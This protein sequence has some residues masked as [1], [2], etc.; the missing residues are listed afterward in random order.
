MQVEA[1]VPLRICLSQFNRWLQTLRLEK[2]LIF[3]TRQHSASAPPPSRKLCTFLTWSDWDLGVC[4]HYECKRKQIHKPDAVNSWIDLRSTYRMFYSRKPKGLNGALQD[5]GIQFCGREHSGLDDA[6]NTARL[7][8]RMMR[9]GCVMKITRSLEREEKPKNKPTTST[10]SSVANAT[11]V[12][13]LQDNSGPR[14]SVPGHESLVSPK[15]LLNGTTSPLC[16]LWSKTRCATAANLSNNL[17]LCSTVM[18]GLQ[19]QQAVRSGPTGL[20]EERVEEFAVEAEDRCGSYDDVV[21]DDVGMDSGGT[22]EAVSDH[23]SLW[24]EPKETPA[25]TAVCQG[26]VPGGPDACFAVLQTASRHQLRHKTNKTP[27]FVPERT[28]TPNASIFRTKGGIAPSKSPFTVLADSWKKVAASASRRVPKTVLSSIPA[29]VIP[30]RGGK[31]TPPLCDCGRRTKR[32]QVS[33]SGP[34]HGRGFY[35]CA[36]R[37]ATRKGCEFFKWESTLKKTSSVS[38]CHADRMLG[39]RRSQRKS[40]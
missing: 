6:K 33:N 38:L 20:E 24:G 40:V 37:Q 21:L 14:V 5:L 16:G 36:V 35:C 15:T 27:S 30:S 31:I 10:P 12:Q 26:D 34:N 19:Q 18:G 23:Y 3:P 1:G 28:S 25:D 39:P 32:L 13:N 8:E 9:D 29:N 17:I 2:A 22:L 7:A 4:L 11:K